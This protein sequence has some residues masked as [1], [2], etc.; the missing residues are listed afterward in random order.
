MRQAPVRLLPKL[1]NALPLADGL[2]LT[3]E[4]IL[5]S[6]PA[7]SALLNVLRATDAE[8]CY[9]Y[10]YDPAM[11]EMEYARFFNPTVGLWEH[12]ATGTAAGPLAAYLAHEGIIGSGVLAIEQGTKT[13]RRSVLNIELT[14]DAEL[15][16]SGII[17]MYGTLVL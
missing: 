11:P 12:A 16:G 5:N 2:G 15:S 13:G 6:P 4:E 14:P 10:S 3:A 7:A 17:V 1:D 8:G 9:I